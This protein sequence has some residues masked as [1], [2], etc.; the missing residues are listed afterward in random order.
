MANEPPNPYA[1]ST[2]LAH[3]AAAAKKA[4]RWPVRVLAAV[5]TWLA[6]P[7]IG[8]GFVVLGRRRR[9]VPWLVT[10]FLLFAIALIAARVPQPRL[11]VGAFAGAYLA[12]LL[13]VIHTALTK[14]GDG[15]TGGRAWLV[16]LALILGA[17][18]AGLVI[19]YTLVE[20]FRVPSGSNV[21]TLLVGDHIF[22]KKGHGTV[23][24]G[25]VI[26]FRYPLD[27]STD[28]IKRVVAIGG[29]TIEVKNGVP[30]INGTPLAQ[31][32]IDAPCSFRDES[33]P[34]DGAQDCT[35]ARETN[36]G[37]A[38][39]VML[40]SGYHAQDFDR[41]VVPSGEVF[42]MGDN[43]DNSMDSRKWG[44][45]PEGLIKGTATVIWW[46]AEPNGAVRW[47]RVGHGI[48]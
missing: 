22:V 4:P 30:S 11:C 6:F 21:P 16:A 3:E 35:L 34:G 10:G 46:S 32:A 8:A 36:A 9:L 37:R 13:A 31:T 26:V 45:L 39:T 43:R 42:V 24:R 29:D 12:C 7:L 17:K 44:P 20:A 47:S 23:A 33:A 48:E 40:T 38:Y 5:T 28:Y 15:F 19:K 2:A 27:P 41:I 18:G 14:P 25:D 1:P